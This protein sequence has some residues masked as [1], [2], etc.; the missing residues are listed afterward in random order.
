MRFIRL[1]LLQA[2]YNLVAYTRSARTVIF[3]VLMP[4]G[5]L[6][7]FNSVLGAKSK[8]I[9]VSKAEESKGWESVRV[10]SLKNWTRVSL[11]MASPL[12][13]VCSVPANVA[14]R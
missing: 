9:L 4:V 2:Q 14:R 7:L 11:R 3:G 12:V 13:M 5:F 10:H 6:M 1:S 8:S